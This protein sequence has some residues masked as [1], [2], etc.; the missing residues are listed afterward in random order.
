[1]VLVLGFWAAA[2]S[3]ACQC[4]DPVTL[5]S[6]Y[7][8][9]SHAFLATIVSSSAAT[10]GEQAFEARVF[11]QYKGFFL[12]KDANIGIKTSIGECGASLQVGTAFVIFA[13]IVD[14]ANLDNDARALSNRLLDANACLVAVPQSAV[15][16]CGM[17]YLRSRY[18]CPGSRL[19]CGLLQNTANCT[20]DTCTGRCAVAPDQ[21]LSCY[22]P[23]V[24]FGPRTCSKVPACPEAA[25][26]SGATCDENTCGACRA[27][28]YGPPPARQPL[29]SE[30]WLGCTLGDGLLSQAPVG[31]TA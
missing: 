11:E 18:W 5:T 21:A 10:A 22:N 7:W 31:I 6:S 15:S 26:V 24:E 27:E 25:R 8:R 23:Q 28:F 30:S 17:A 9:A 29:C 16:P 20:L 14:G 1:M 4:A 3:G 12:P 13:N 19:N 2:A